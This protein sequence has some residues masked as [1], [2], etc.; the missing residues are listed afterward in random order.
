MSNDR[1]RQDLETTY[2]EN[3]NRLRRVAQRIVG[4]RELAEDV[5]QCAYLRLAAHPSDEIIEEPLRYWSQVVRHIALIAAAASTGNRR[6]S[7][8]SRGDKRFRADVP[9]RNKWP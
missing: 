5:L 4:T 7:P 9:R 1:Q 2:V 3:R 8:V 6:C